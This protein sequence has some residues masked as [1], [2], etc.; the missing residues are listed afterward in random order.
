[1]AKICSNYHLNK[2][3]FR[4]Q[5]C[6]MGKCRFLLGENYCKCC[7]YVIQVCGPLAR[8]VH[9]RVKITQG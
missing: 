2:K 4:L 1:M 7:M 8:V 9:S 5:G 6:N 3:L